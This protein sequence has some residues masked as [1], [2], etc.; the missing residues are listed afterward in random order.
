MRSRPTVLLLVGFVAF[1][2]VMAYLLVSSLTRRRAPSFAPSPVGVPLAVSSTGGPDT[3]TVDARRESEWRYLD[4]D[5]RLALAPGDSAGWDLAMQRFRIR[6]AHGA[7][8]IARAQNARSDLEPWSPDFGHWYSYGALS[9][10][11]EPAGRVFAVRT[12]RGRIAQVEIVSYYCPGLEAGCLT[13]RY[14][15]PPEGSRP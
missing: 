8:V 13:L 1:L 9:H 11:L 2:A 10:L 5:L 12:D 4:L 6:A 14:L 3:V 7:Q 15:L